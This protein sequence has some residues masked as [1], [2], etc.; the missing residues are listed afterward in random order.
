MDVEELIKNGFYAI[1][2]K[3]LLLQAYEEVFNKKLCKTCT[4]SYITAYN[5]L[6]AYVM[7]SKK[8][9]KNNPE[10]TIKQQHIND[11]MCVN[12]KVIQLS[13]ITQAEI[14]TYIIPHKSNHHLL[15]EKA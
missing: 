12:G 9:P 1:K 11:T 5:A 3:N 6:N 7:S 2:E 13:T 4:G 15:N 14:K 8:Q 10:F